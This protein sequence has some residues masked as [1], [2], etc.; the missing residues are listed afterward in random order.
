MKR[1]SLN[2]NNPSTT[3]GIPTYEAGKSLVTTLNSIYGQ[4]AFADVKKILVVVDGKKKIDKG[5]LMAVKHHKLEVVYRASRK[6]QSSRINDIL[7]LT[8]TKILI[9][10]NDDVIWPRNTL[11]HLLNKSKVSSADL[12]TTTAVPM[13]ARNAIEWTISLGAI[14]TAQISARWKNYH[15]YLS[16]N[17]RLLLLSKP[18]FSS[19]KIP[20]KLWN[21]DAYIYFFAKY[22]GFTHLHQ[23]KAEVRYRSPRSLSD[24]LKQSHKFQFSLSE[25]QAFFN[26]DLSADYQIPPSETKRA[27]ISSLITS[28]F[29]TALF[30]LLTLFTRFTSHKNSHSGVGY[31]ATDTSTKNI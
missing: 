18:L 1:N 6:G 4:T 21:N 12:I 22:H 26:Q 14:L 19:M 17:G 9:L 24:H 27:L 8:K 11:K 13:P 28:P 16:C 30:I 25:N 7:K 2:I 10:T 15:N 5:I 3:I 20:S 29:R 31:W 23:P